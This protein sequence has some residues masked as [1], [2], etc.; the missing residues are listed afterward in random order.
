VFDGGKAGNKIRSID[1]FREETNTLSE[2]ASLFKDGTNSTLQGANV[3]GHNEHKKYSTGTYVSRGE[4]T[5][6]YVTY[7]D[8]SNS[9]HFLKQKPLTLL[10]DLWRHYQ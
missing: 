4:G 3:R 10:A 7:R 1:I 9:Y 8:V 2:A 5:Y 6:E